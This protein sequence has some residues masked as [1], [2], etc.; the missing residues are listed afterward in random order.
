MI[1]RLGAPGKVS[2]VEIDTN[3]FKGNFPDSVSLEAVSQ[4]NATLEELLSPQTK[5]SP[6]LPQTKLT[7]HEQHRYRS[8]VI[9]NETITHV[10]L[11][12]FP[13]GGI[14]RLR[15]YGLRSEEA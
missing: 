10:R 13:D 9:S 4:A 3:H 7:A 2:L 14:S 12:I 8:E 11:N 5:W 1:L 6:L 15:L